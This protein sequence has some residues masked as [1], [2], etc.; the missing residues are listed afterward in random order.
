MRG[1]HRLSADEQDAYCA[2]C[3]RYLCC[4][5]RA[6]VIKATKR[7]SHRYDRRVSKRKDISERLKEVWT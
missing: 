2:W 4:L 5:Q 1:E 6:G 3:R 7:R